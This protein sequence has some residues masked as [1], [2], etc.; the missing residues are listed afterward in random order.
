ML[1]LKKIFDFIH[2]KQNISTYTHS[3]SDFTRL[4]KLTFPAVV[5]KILHSF[6]DSVEF[7]LATFLP[8]LNLRPVTAGAFSIARCKIKIDFFKD[9]DKVLQDTIET[10]QPKRW[11]GYRLIAGDGTTISVPVSKQTISYF[12]VFAQSKEGSKTVMANACMLY[13]VLANF[14]LKSAIST[15]K[16]NEYVLMKHMLADFTS[17][18]SILLL[19]RAFG[20]FYIYKLL[21]SNGLNFCIRQKV[22][23]A[24]NFSKSILSTNS[25]DFNAEWIPSEAE[26][27]SCKIH[28]LT[29]EPIKV[30]IT[31]VLLPSGEIEILVSNLFD[32][33]LIKT[34]DMKTLYH[35]RW[36]IEEA[37]KQLKPKMKLEQ[38]G[39]RKPEGIFQEFYAHLIMLNL[40]TLIALE[41]EPKIHGKANTRKWPYKY[42]RVNAY[43]FIKTAFVDLFY[44]TDL[45]SIM[46]DLIEKISSSIISIRPN[47]NFSRKHKFKRKPRLSPMYK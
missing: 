26:M 8:K 35:Y 11:K 25:S 33:E 34:E 40:T 36:S 17:K 46:D 14:V 37:F 20:Y 44:N 3:A 23:V 2:N 9:L 27:A 47:R 13:D 1:A 32:F 24:Q 41:A 38:F 10:I 7:N 31:K 42:N 29:S 19:D 45:Q 16:E 30:R 12:A 15:T 18:D 6:S 43:K 5:L 22:D 39:S 4:N 21:L 28:G